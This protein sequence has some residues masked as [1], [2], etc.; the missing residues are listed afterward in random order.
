M[1]RRHFINQLIKG[2]AVASVVPAIV[3]PIIQSSKK[4]IWINYG[5]GHKIWYD[6]EE[7]QKMLEYNE[8]LMEEANKAWY[9]RT[10]KKD[11]ELYTIWR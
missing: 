8:R 9:G 7:Y 2:L 1:E 4:V 5:D 10:R 3:A 11:V 6:W